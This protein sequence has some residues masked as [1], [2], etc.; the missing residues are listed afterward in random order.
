MNSLV[1]QAPEQLVLR[2]EAPPKA[3]RAGEVLVRV[4]RVGVCGT[5]LHAFSGRQPFF[6][7][8]RRLGHELGVEILEVG[9]GVHLKPG[10]KG[11]VEPYLNCE[12]CIACRRGKPN[13]CVNLKVLG[14]HEDGGMCEFLTLPARKLHI[15]D[16]LDFEQL[17]LVEALAIG[18]HAV[19]RAQIER[20]EWVLVRGAGPIGL[21]VMQFARQR[22]AQVIAL[23]VNP[24]RLQFCRDRWN[25]SHTVLG[26]QNALEAVRELTS[27]DL[28]TTVFDATGHRDSMNGAFDFVA[29]GGK[30]VFVGLHRGEVSFSDPDF[31]RRELTVLAS[32][33]ALPQDF[34]NITGWMENGEIQ[35]ANWI[36]HRAKLAEVP[37][38]FASWT[39]P[40][41]G[42]LKAMIE[43]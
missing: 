32:R 23:D 30:L 18:A 19:A 2:E 11:A 16:A 4:H 26:D 43:I 8:P 14:V 12:K 42:V 40:E 27:G 24:N 1:L 17:A 29:H 10:Q 34:K 25:V 6:E 28:P 41:S 5:D 36:S 33:N 3:P 38:L 31:H 21:G 39:R 37:S 7:F 20:G 22:G 35:T 9:A 13:C 15:C